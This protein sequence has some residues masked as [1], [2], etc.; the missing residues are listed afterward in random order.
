MFLNKTW[1]LYS[2]INMILKDGGNEHTIYYNSFKNKC[3]HHQIKISTTL[4]TM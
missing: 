1:K 4:K 3:T 2:L